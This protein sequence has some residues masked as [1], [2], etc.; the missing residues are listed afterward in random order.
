MCVARE[1]AS[2]RPTFT[3]IAERA[4]ATWFISVR[5]VPGALASVRR[6]DRIESTARAAIARELQLSKDSFDIE[7][8]ESGA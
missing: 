6:H 4:G 7:I 8:S 1:L 2:E 5:D 3:V